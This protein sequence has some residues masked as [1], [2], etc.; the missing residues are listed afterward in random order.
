MSDEASAFEMLS[1]HVRAAQRAGEL[2]AGD[3][4]LM[5]ALIVGAVVGAADVLR[6]ARPNHERRGRDA[7]IPPLLLIDLLS[8]K[9]CN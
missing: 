5:T 7:E 4:S 1:R 6:Y 3:P 8:T 9:G 2:K